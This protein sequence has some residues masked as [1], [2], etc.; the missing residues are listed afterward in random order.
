MTFIPTQSGFMR[1]EDSITAESCRRYSLAE[2]LI[3]GAM[4]VETIRLASGAS[5][6]RKT[7]VTQRGYLS[8]RDFL[9]PNVRKALQL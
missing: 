3:V 1:L 4:N 5:I 9:R 6:R 2:T 8:A 7:V